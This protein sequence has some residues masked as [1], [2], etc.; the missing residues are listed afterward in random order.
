MPP[1]PQPSAY[2]FTIAKQSLIEKFNSCIVPK[3]KV[4]KFICNYSQV[5]LLFH[6]RWLFDLLRTLIETVQWHGSQYLSHSDSFLGQVS[7]TFCEKGRKMR[8][9]IIGRCKFI[10]LSNIYEKLFVRNLLKAKNH[11]LFLKKCSNVTVF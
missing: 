2:L 7:F 6:D 11:Y 8:I 10:T 4:A 1:N 3:I 5:A 9:Y